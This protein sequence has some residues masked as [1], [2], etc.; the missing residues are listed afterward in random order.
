M[1]HFENHTIVA[2]AKTML[3]R[4]GEW[5]SKFERVWLLRIEFE[6]INDPFLQA[7][8]ESI[9]L[10]VRGRCKLHPHVETTCRDAPLYPQG[11]YLRRAAL[12]DVIGLARAL[13]PGR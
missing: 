2:D 3:I 11:R 12:L 1:E 4:A 5:F 8:G 9:Q 7:A 6:L 10:L 13:L